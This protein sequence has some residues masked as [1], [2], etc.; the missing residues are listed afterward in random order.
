M[1]NDQKWMINMSSQEVE[2]KFFGGLYV[3]KNAL[4]IDKATPVSVWFFKAETKLSVNY[5][6]T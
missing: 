5:Q 6:Q 3:L 2:Y 4:R 1:V